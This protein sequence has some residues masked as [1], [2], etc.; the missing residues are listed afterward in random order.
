[1][2]EAPLRALV[3]QDRVNVSGEKDLILV[4]TAVIMQIAI[5]CHQISESNFHAFHG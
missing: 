4:I 3:S 1:M 2:K 5:I